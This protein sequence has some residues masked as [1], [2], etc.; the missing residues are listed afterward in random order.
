MG[1]RTGIYRTCNL[2]GCEE[3]VYVQHYLTKSTKTSYC[4]KHKEEGRL[5]GRPKTGIYRTCCHEGC[6]EQVYVQLKK[7]KESKTS[8]C[9]KHKTPGRKKGRYLTCYFKGCEE[10]VWVK[11]YEERIHLTYSCKEHKKKGRRYG[12]YKTCSYGDCKEQ[13]YFSPSELEKHQSKQCKNHTTKEGRV[14]NWFECTNPSCK[15]MVYRTPSRQIEKGNTEFFCSRPCNYQVNLHYFRPKKTKPEIE[16]E[17]LLKEWKVS[18]KVEY[19]VYWKENRSKY[20]DFYLP[21]YNL[22]VEVD[23]TYFHSKGLKVSEMNQLQ[24]NSNRTDRLKNLLSRERGYQLVR[25][26]EDEIELLTS[27]EVLLNKKRVWDSSK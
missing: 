6:E 22:L 7:S 25:V 8:T 9:S 5:S 16:V 19:P 20:Y 10:Q 12:E 13:V 15:E 24:W 23:G 21:D 17:S 18:Y 26:W 2:D 3:Q 1:K 11:P 4:E 27:F 14:E